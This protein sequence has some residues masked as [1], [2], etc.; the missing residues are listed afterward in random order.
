[1]KSIFK[2]NKPYIADGAAAKKEEKISRVEISI[3]FLKS[4]EGIMDIIAGYKY[5]E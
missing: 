2:E 1:M 4:N 3:E 5:G